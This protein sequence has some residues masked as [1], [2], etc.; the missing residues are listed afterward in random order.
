MDNETIIA[1][2]EK[3]EK[4]IESLINSNQTLENANRELK[5]KVERLETELQEKVDSES[6]N[7]EVRTLI[8]NKIDG[9][10]ERLEG[11]TETEA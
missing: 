4:R 7:D 3:I 6:R 11:I 2:F 10:M 9:L 8:R 1:Q 5:G